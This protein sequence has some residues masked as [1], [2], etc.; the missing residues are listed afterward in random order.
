MMKIREVGF[1]C[2]TCRKYFREVSIASLVGYTKAIQCGCGS[3]K[4]EEEDEDEV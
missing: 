1:Q 2:K 3:W 4:I